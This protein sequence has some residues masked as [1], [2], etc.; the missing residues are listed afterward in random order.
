M[1]QLLNTIKRLTDKPNKSVTVTNMDTAKQIVCSKR[2]SQ[3]IE[4]YGNVENF[5]NSLYESGVTKIKVEDRNPSGT[6]TTPDGEPYFVSLVPGEESGTEVTT[7]PTVLEVKTK[8]PVMPAL[9]G[10]FESIGLNAAQIDVAGKLYDYPRIERELREAT[11][12]NKRL[13]TENQELKTK[14]L[15]S[16][17]MEG[18]SVAKTEANTK[19][20][21]QFAPLL[22]AVA[23]KFLAPAPVA[24]A[25]G[26]AGTAS[27]STTKQRVV[28]LISQ[29]DDS[30]VHYL[31]LLIGKLH[32]DSVWNDFEELLKKNDLAPK[33]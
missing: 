7:K 23:Q 8:Q 20:M 2:G 11:A 15:V 29:Q 10:A 9:S 14:I 33:E 19:L 5:F 32:E 3:L 31:G 22:G 30:I 18:K 4:E 1:K 17:T 6:S 12:E 27:L 24:E 26:L 21:E 13:T 25:A 28:A 16:D